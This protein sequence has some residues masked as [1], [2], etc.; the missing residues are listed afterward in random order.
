MKKAKS[1]INVLEHTLVPEMKI[2]PEGQKNAVLEKYS[3][4]SQYQLPHMKKSDP[5]AVALGAKD[6]DIVKIEREEP[7]GKCVYYRVVVA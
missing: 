3:L 2:V 7:T 5:A 6:G 4:N 1:I